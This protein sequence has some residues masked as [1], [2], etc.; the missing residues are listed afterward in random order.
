MTF[1]RMHGIRIGK[2]LMFVMGLCYYYLLAMYHSPDK[3][4]NQE[5]S[6]S[7]MLFL[8]VIMSNLVINFSNS[9]FCLFGQGNFIVHWLQ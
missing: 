7:W 9:K 6:P 1:Y 3:S 2:G 5:N 4:M 8:T